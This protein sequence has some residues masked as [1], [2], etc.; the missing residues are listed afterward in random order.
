MKVGSPKARWAMMP[1]HNIQNFVVK[2]YQ[3][4]F[5]YG[6]FPPTN[7]EDKLFPTSFSKGFMGG[8]IT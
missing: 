8:L 1:Y 4:F 3:G 5:A 6:Q 2:Y 7:D